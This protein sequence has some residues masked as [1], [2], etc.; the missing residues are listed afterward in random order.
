MEGVE[1]VE[2]VLEETASRGLSGRDLS[3]V[4]GGIAVGAGLGAT[5]GFFLTRRH[6]ETKYNQITQDEIETMR[7]HFHARLIARDEKPTLSELAKDHKQIVEDQKYSSAPM[8]ITPPEEIV[9]EMTRTPETVEI[10]V[11]ENSPGPEDVIESLVEHKARIAREKNRNVFED[12]KVEDNWDYHLERSRRSPNRPYVIHY[13][14]KDDFEYAESTFTYYE[15]DDVL[16]DE[17]DQV[18]DPDR[19][20]EIIGEA[21]LNRFGHGSNSPDV[22]YV[23][24]DTLEIVFEICKSEGSYAE[25]VHGFIQHAEERR[26]EKRR[27]DDERTG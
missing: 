15:Q 8:A 13:D 21:N 11:S 9:E 3:L 27:F 20:D 4:F 25:E 19:R 5:L 26:K 6:L 23:R 24:N 10:T 12:N 22:V 16:C 1:V 18:V 17:T 2:E 14:E 7:E